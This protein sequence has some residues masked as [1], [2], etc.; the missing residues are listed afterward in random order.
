MVGCLTG[1]VRAGSRRRAGNRRNQPGR[2]SGDTAPARVAGRAVLLSAIA[3]RQLLAS[4]IRQCHLAH[5]LL[6]AAERMAREQ[7]AA[8]FRS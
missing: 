7:S 1:L 6:R 2:V 8:G 5:A 4:R 3:G